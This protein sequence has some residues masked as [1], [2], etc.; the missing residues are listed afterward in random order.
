LIKI[1]PKE[2]ERIK[3]IRGWKSS[4]D[5]EEPVENN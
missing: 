2:Y 5:G 4:R 3:W 1:E